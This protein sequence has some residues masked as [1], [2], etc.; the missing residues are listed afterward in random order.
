MEQ[1]NYLFFLN[2]VFSLE[3]INKDKVNNDD[4]KLSSKS[5]NF[6]N[7]IIEYNLMYF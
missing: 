5:N 2:S 1:K 7:N 3:N 6:K 4:K